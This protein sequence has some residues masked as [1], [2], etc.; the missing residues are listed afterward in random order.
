MANLPERELLV[1]ELL[2]F[3][4]KVSAAGN[5]SFEAWRARDHDDTVLATAIGIWYG[6]QGGRRLAAD[7]F[8][9]P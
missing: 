1:K 2:A 7:S 6:E 3:K 9:L 8:F 4:V 5:E